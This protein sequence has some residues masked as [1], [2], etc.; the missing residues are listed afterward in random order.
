M[1]GFKHNVKSVLNNKSEKS[2]IS[3]EEI[4][5]M[6]EHKHE[7]YT[8]AVTAARDDL[9]ALCMQ[10]IDHSKKHGSTLEASLIDK[11][12]E[13]VAT[14]PHNPKNQNPQLY[15]KLSLSNPEFGDVD[16]LQNY[17]GE[18]P[19]KWDSDSK[20]NVPMKLTPKSVISYADKNNPDDRP[21]KAFRDYATSVWLPE[22]LEF[23][24]FVARNKDKR[25]IPWT[26][27]LIIQRADGYDSCEWD[28]KE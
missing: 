20:Q 7:I 2:E 1:P 15:G 22:G 21:G 10:R 16:L 14:A 23:K 19:T 4:Q 24:V 5:A 8:Q 12:R 18:K 3:K 26:Y 27:N 17:D 6:K 9:T 25:I 13:A 11:W 28:A